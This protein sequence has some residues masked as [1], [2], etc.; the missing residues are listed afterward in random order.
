M[1]VKTKK[2]LITGGS[3]GIG[4]GL[5]VRFLKAGSQVMVTGR[6]QG[7]LE[8]LA[9][10]YPGILTFVN[11]IGKAEERE[12]LAKHVMEQFGNL[13]ILINNAGIQ[14]RT[15][16]A[17]DHSPWKERQ[18]EIDI[19]LSA[20]VH[21]NHLLIPQILKNNQPGMIINVT[22]GGA[23]IPQV[24]APV[25]SACKAAL[26][27]YTLTL[28]HALSNTRCKVIELVPPAVQTALAG[29]GLSHGVPVEDFCDHVFHE[30]ITGKAHRIGFGPTDYLTEEIS[31]RPVKDLMAESAVK[32]PVKT[33]GDFY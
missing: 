1:D 12:W 33:Y 25:Y 3:D 21:L 8:R 30:I 5:A 22:S 19:L 6:N 31:G 32:F 26:H 29:P 17:E 20:P 14:R 28:A 24:F 10:E 11:D 23:Y 15:A 7:K 13:N 9:R 18:E 16:L 2:V 4:K 27:S